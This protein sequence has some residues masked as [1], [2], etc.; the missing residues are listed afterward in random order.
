MNVHFQAPEGSVKQSKMLLY[1]VLEDM[2]ASFSSH[3]NTVPER[4]YEA[5][6]D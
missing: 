3:C 5:E 4:T 6:S 1:K 2:E